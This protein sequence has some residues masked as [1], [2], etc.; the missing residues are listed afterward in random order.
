VKQEEGKTHD[1]TWEFFK[2]RIEL[3][4]IPKNFD[5]ISK[6]KLCDLVNAINNLHQYVRVYFKCM[7]E[8]RHMHEL[9]CVCYFVMG[10]LIRAKCNLENNWLV[11][12]S[13]AIMKVEGFSDVGQGEKSGFKKEKI[14]SQEGTP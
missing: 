5:Y 13:E 9:D 7:L 6:C 12:L 3:E 11:S 2:E 10:F 14:P 8:I 4:F 1:Y